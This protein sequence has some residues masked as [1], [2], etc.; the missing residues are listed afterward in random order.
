MQQP[1]DLRQVKQARR[2]IRLACC[3]LPE[4]LPRLPEPRSQ[5]SRHKTLFF[6]PPRPL[7]LGFIRL[8]RSIFIKPDFK[9]IGPIYNNDNA[10][11]NLNI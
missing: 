10:M 1:I 9:M 4:G 7:E 2:P 3:Q 5:P 8:A 6:L 11:A